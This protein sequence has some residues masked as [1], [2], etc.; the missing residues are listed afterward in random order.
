MTDYRQKYENERTARKLAE[1][2][3]ELL[4]KEV[5]LL[6]IELKQ[7]GRH[8]SPSISQESESEQSCYS[9]NSE[10]SESEEEVAKPTR[11]LRKKPQKSKSSHDVIIKPVKQTLA[12]V[13]Y[14]V[15][16][17]MSVFD[18]SKYADSMEVNSTYE[19]NLFDS[20][21]NGL[22]SKQV[23][24]LM[25]TDGKYNVYDEEKGERKWVECDMNR[26]VDK[27]YG[28]IHNRILKM[29][30][31]KAKIKNFQ[32][33]EY[34]DENKR[35]NEDDFLLTLNML[36]KIDTEKLLKSRSRALAKMFKN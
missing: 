30:N 33:C 17:D 18:Y 25:T 9:S 4:R 7:A 11:P 1:K 3:C 20:I 12:E 16:D 36:C 22:S 15:I 8:R 13:I 2:E 29:F 27:T 28:R 5:E 34:P 26:L 31:E 21:I 14:D 23:P 32:G 24:I 19:I 6:K 35:T 10:S